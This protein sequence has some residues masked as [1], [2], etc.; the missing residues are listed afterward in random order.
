MRTVGEWADLLLE[1][2]PEEAVEALRDA[3]TRHGDRATFFEETV[4]P[5]Q[6]E[7][8][9]RWAS[10][11]IGVADEHRAS[12]LVAEA[13]A[14]AAAT[15]RSIGGQSRVRAVVACVEG[16]LHALAARMAADAAIDYGWRVTF[17]GANVPTRELAR[18][19][20]Q[21]KANVVL[22]SA[23]T[24]PNLRQARHAIERLREV[25]PDAV[26]AVGGRGIVAYPEVARTLGADVIESDL[27]A[28]LEAIEERLGPSLAPERGS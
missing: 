2:D 9:E 14:H 20:A 22:L 15:R 4:A 25:A 10:N 5:I 19:V 23:A 26:V 28:A 12:N 24:L 11:A 18:Y 27:N 8:G 6:R 1:G 7:I 16:E 3:L 13:L 21:S 17:L